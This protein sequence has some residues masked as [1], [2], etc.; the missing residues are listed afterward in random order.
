[1]EFL[2]GKYLY[3]ALIQGY[4]MVENWLLLLLTSH[5]HVLVWTFELGKGISCFVDL[6]LGMIFVN[7]QLDAQFFMYV[8]LHSLHVSVSHVS[9]IRGIILSMR[10]WFMSLCV[11]VG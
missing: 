2:I 3:N 8:Y 1:M 11:D 7:I 4:N 10:N 6:H 5:W 9:I